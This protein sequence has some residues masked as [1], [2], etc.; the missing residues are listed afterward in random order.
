MDRD[1]TSFMNSSPRDFECALL[2][3]PGILHYREGKGGREGRVIDLPLDRVISRVSSIRHS[4]PTPLYFIQ[5]QIFSQEFRGVSIN[6]I[7]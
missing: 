3:Y 7:R 4:L 2:F 1:A 6:H 5:R